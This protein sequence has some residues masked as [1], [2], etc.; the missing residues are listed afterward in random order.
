M[1]VV[2]C[3]P[4][5]AKCSHSPHRAPTS[6]PAAMVKAWRSVKG[7]MDDYYR[8]SASY[9]GHTVVDPEGE[10]VGKVTKVIYEG[11][12]DAMPAW[13]VVDRG[14]LR[15]EHYVPASGAYATPDDRVIVPFP[16]RWIK[17]A[18]R[19]DR[20]DLTPPTRRELRIHYQLG[21]A[22]S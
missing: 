1:T 18:P 17:A 20:V 8:L 21:Q 19:A 2:R 13:M 22:G 5:V 16:K 9:E 7:R 10:T 4:R 12:S 14:L 15:P 6:L 11:D 3:F